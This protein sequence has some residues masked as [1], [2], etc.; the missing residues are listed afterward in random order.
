LVWGEHF[1]YTCVVNE[2][3]DWAQVVFYG[4]HHAIYFCGFGDVGLD[5]DGL[6]ACGAD[7]IANDIGSGSLGVVI[8]RDL[9]T[10]VG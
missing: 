7:L 10:C 5:G 4:L 9:G 6:A 8:H 1:G 3:G 2:D